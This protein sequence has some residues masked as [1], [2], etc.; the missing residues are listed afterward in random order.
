MRDSL[1]RFGDRVADYD[2]WRP[3][4]PDE[5]LATLRAAGLRPEHAVADIG[6]GT[7][8]LSAVFLAH[9][10]R[11][12]GVEPNAAMAEAAVRRFEGRPFTAVPGR[13]E[14]TGLPAA[15]VD[16][17][18]SGQ[19]FHWFE[20][21]PA[22]AE[23]RRILRPG[24][25]GLAAIAWNLRPRE[26]SGFLD[27]YESLLLRWGTDYRQV[28]ERYADKAALAIFFGGEGYTCHRFGHAQRLDREGLRGRLLSSSYT[29]PAGHPDRVPMLA[30]LDTLFDAHA[31]DGAVSF[32]YVTELY[33]GRLR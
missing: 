2:R 26:G 17:I 33:L 3:G 9:G 16:L 23:A 5:V 13:A 19:A 21:A 11:V 25:L 12:F 30:A 15:H 18:T 31:R 4:Y 8:L 32:P 14:A 6:S 10:N 24:P 1:E 20:P 27:G 28:A 7:G 22:A 29:P